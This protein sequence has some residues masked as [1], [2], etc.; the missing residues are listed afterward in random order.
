ML[1]QDQILSHLDIHM[2]LSDS[3]DLLA[4]F[5]CGSSWSVPIRPAIHPTAAESLPKCPPAV[6]WFKAAEALAE[7][8]ATIANWPDSVAG[9][10][11]L[12]P[13]ATSNRPTCYVD[14]N[15]NKGVRFTA[16]RQWCEGEAPLEYGDKTF[17]IAA[18]WV[19]Y[20]TKI[21]AIWEQN[22]LNITQ[23]RRA[24]LLQMHGDYGFDGEGCDGH[25]NAKAELNEV[26]ITVLRHDEYHVHLL[27]D[28]NMTV[29]DVASCYNG[30]GNA[31]FL[32]GKK[33]I[34]DGEFL[35]GLIY[36][37]RVWDRALNYFEMYQVH[38]ELQ[39][40]KEPNP[41][42]ILS[43]C[44]IDPAAAVCEAAPMFVGGGDMSC[45]AGAQH[46]MV[47]QLLCKDGYQP[48]GDLL[49]CQNGLWAGA[50]C[51]EISMCGAPVFDNM[52]D[53]S[54]C[55]TTETCAV[56]CAKH[57]LPVRSTINCHLGAWDIIDP[58]TVCV[59][60][61]CLTPPFIPNSIVQS[62][63]APTADGGPCPVVCLEGYIGSTTHVTCVAGTW[64]HGICD[65]AT[66]ATPPVVADSSD[67]SSCA[68]TQHG[69]DCA[70]SCVTGY[71]PEPPFVNCSNGTWPD[72]KCIPSSCSSPPLV[73]FSSGMQMCV[74]IPSGGVCAISCAPGF[75]PS[76]PTSQCFNGK[77]SDVICAQGAGPA[78]CT[79][80]PAVLHGDNTE[81]SKCASTLDGGICTVACLSGYQTSTPFVSCVAGTWTM[82][83]CQ[84]MPCGQPPM[85]A[86]A[87]DL[88][89]CAGAS[90]GDVCELLCST[91]YQPSSAAITCVRGV[92]SSAEC[93]PI[94]SSSQC[95]AQPPV[96]NGNNLK[97]QA[98]IY[99]SDG[100]ICE[101]AC[102]PGHQPS[103]AM[104]RCNAGTWE[105]ASCL[106]A[107]C[108]DAPIIQNSKDLSPCAG[109]A[110]TGTCVLSCAPG[111][112]PSSNHIYCSRGQWLEA[113]CVAQP[114]PFQCSVPPSVTN[115]N[116]EA[117][118]K[119][120]PSSNMD[121]CVVV[122][123]T[124]FQPTAVVVKCLAG[125][126]EDTQ[127]NPSPCMAPPSIPHAAEVS[128]C[129]GIKS[130]GVCPL[131]CIPGYAPSSSSIE[132]INGKWAEPTCQPLSSCLSPPDVVNSDPVI[133]GSTC[134]GMLDG[135]LCVM[136]CLPG[137][138]AL[139]AKL[140]CVAGSW[141]P[142]SCKATA[143][144]HAPDIAFSNMASCAGTPVG[145][146]CE[147]VCEANH[148]PT[149]SG[150][151]CTA[152]GTWSPAVLCQKAAVC[153]GAPLVENSVDMSSCD[154]TPAGQSCALL[155]QPGYK[156]SPSQIPCLGSWAQVLFLCQ[157]YA[158]F[159]TTCCP[160]AVCAWMACM[161]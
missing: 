64:T 75:V 43:G 19:T 11:C 32:M 113:A 29:R 74:N 57:F 102:N 125:T 70:I 22:D 7:A 86:H 30:V 146:L 58:S 90:G 141:T 154:G 130:G 17:T 160:C 26:Q 143:C 55:E 161:L 6:Q 91:G 76:S 134:Q 121:K 31:K 122:C 82:S 3:A 100:Q 59:S 120:V 95:A 93:L 151:M 40:Y 28:G 89:A 119:C 133:L 138:E 50:N 83:T 147:V 52:G 13:L 116:P 5:N 87:D 39:I 115:G 62:D 110:S 36:E 137:F 16:D 48:S 109:T 78:K 14:V 85:I 144:T 84:E 98:C 67:L 37:V 25:D 94:D 51:E 114:A 149:L 129:T 2:E 54:V 69:N 63:C 72:A 68:F 123:K 1:R 44:G 148:E 112:T 150:I 108:L 96:P 56:T 118:Q 45:C 155:C 38:Q 128:A 35:D 127:C 158:V 92:W 65:P 156:A 27:D 77:W 101:V 97:M 20:S 47:C 42:A 140:Q 12:Q 157:L 132:C 135:S 81:L 15:G 21:S 73:S 60:T 104:V 9:R 152:D 124:G 79:L 8:D 33:H 153:L 18:A 53:M 105:S 111:Y 24:A 4:V 117:L 41:C 103:V 126:W 142:G 136:A 139:P 131:V 106:E 159:V 88:S 23:G 107:A 10:N 99:A 34:P 66:C 46:G 61:D 80:A 71:H 49:T 145:Q